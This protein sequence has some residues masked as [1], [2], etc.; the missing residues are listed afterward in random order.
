MEV[1][2]AS[3][4]PTDSRRPP[5]EPWLLLEQA[6]RAIRN[7]Q[8][9]TTTQLALEV[10]ATASLLA[11]LQQA[12][13]LHGVHAPRRVSPRRLRQWALML[14]NPAPQVGRTWI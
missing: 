14:A 4:A 12:S 11:A 7:Q 13:R 5:P 2:R 1:A 3:L 10:D 8:G 9:P 6:A